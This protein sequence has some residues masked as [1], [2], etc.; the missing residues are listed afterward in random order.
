LTTRKRHSRELEKKRESRDAA[1]MKGTDDLQQIGLDLES[2]EASV[3]SVGRLAALS[4]PSAEAGQA[5][6]CWLG[7]ADLPEAAELLYAMESKATD[8]DLK[9]EIRRSLFR[10]EQHGVVVKVATRAAAPALVKETDRGFLSPVDARGDQVV[11]FVKEESSGDYFVLSGVVN[12]RRGLVEADAGRV[13]RPAF[14]DLVE[15]TH[16]RFGLR[17]LPASAAW[18]DRVLHEAYKRSAHRRNPGVSRFPA[19]RMEISHQLPE[20]IP[21]PVRGLLGGEDLRERMDLLDSSQ[22]LLEEQE[23]AGWSLDPEW[24]E[25]YRE[26]FREATESSLVLSRFQ[27]EER[28]DRAVRDAASAIFG[29]EASQVYAL[30]LEAMAYYFHLDKRAG[31]ALHA[32]AVSSA[33]A[34]GTLQAPGSLPFTLELTRRSLTAAAE[35]DRAKRH[36]ERGVSLIVKPGEP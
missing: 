32:L 35:A 33:L 17:M 27:K 8:K 34:A 18:C 24:L 3:E 16:H 13:A 12:D 31:Q 9:R 22:R 30:R 11:W 4:P 5:M 25:P 2:L 7:F 1:L 19:Y 23:M 10:L 36:E 15:K 21:C 29:G 14:R 26:G 20:A 6:A 28:A